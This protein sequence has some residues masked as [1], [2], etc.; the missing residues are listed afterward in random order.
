MFKTGQVAGGVPAP[1]AT[2]DIL[3]QVSGFESISKTFYP[4][5]SANNF[6]SLPGVKTGRKKKILF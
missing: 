1:N 5:S 4:P 3:T 6:A 2:S